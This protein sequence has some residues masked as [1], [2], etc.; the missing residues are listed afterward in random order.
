MRVITLNEVEE[1]CK[2]VGVELINR[3]DRI[4]FTEDERILVQRTDG[5]PMNTCYSELESAAL[6]ECYG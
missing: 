1:V 2:I 3:E 6:P 4:R 5:T